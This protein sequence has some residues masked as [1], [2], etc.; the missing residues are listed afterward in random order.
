ML[1]MIQVI[2]KTKWAIP[3]GYIPS[4]STGPKPEMESHDTFCVLN[5]T[6]KTANLEVMVYFQDKEPVGP[7]KM[8]VQGQRT[9]HFRFNEV[10]DPEEIPRDEDFASL[11]VSD[12]PVVVQ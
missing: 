6:D 2:G 5:T 7:Y 12:V 10:K 3:E 9:Q 4:K 8:T 1:N 11:I